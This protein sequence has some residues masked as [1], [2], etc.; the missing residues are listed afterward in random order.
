MSDPE[1]SEQPEQ[2]GTN[3]QPEQ[4]RA[5][6]EPEQA[7]RPDEQ[8]TPA[9]AH[10]STKTPSDYVR[11]DDDPERT[12]VVSR[13]AE[14]DAERTIAVSRGAAE[15]AERTIAVSR[16]DPED[17]A[18]R[19]V[20]A[21]RDATIAVSGRSE[22]QEL[23]ERFGMP[24][25]GPPGLSPAAQTPTQAAPQTERATAR[26]PKTRL[27]PVPQGAQPE[28]YEV[29][30]V[31]GPPPEVSADPPAVSRERL[32][33]TVRA[34]RRFRVLT[35]IGFAV[36]VAVSVTGLWWITTLVLG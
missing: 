31:L 17:D 13:R 18:E 10:E 14:D 23:A 2:P 35:L 34:N 15:D 16:R 4:P 29:G 26:R 33:S 3:E 25:S 32:P 9:V 24:A 11:R 1:Q 36:A 8:E 21:D 6:G 5:N 7:G 30:R 12:I 27:L 22:R 20:I 28:E 19:T